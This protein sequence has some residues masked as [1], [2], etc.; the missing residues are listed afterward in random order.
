VPHAPACHLLFLPRASPQR[1]I[2]RLHTAHATPATLL[3]SAGRAGLLPM[4][5]GLL[6]I[7]LR[8]RCCCCL[9]RLHGRSTIRTPAA[10]LSTT[11]TAGSAYARCR[12]MLPHPRTTIL[13]FCTSDSATAAAVCSAY[14]AR[15][16]L[17]RHKRHT[18]FYACFYITMHCMLPATPAY[19]SASRAAL[20][21]LWVFTLP[22]LEPLHYHCRACRP[23][24][25]DGSVHLLSTYIAPFCCFLPLRLPT[26][27]AYRRNS[28]YRNALLVSRCTR[29]RSNHCA[30]VHCGRLPPFTAAAF[31][32]RF[33]CALRRAS[34]APY[35]PAPRLLACR[36]LRNRRRT[37]A[38]LSRTRLRRCWLFTVAF[39]AST[40][41]HVL[42]RDALALPRH[43]RCTKLFHSL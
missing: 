27:P 5:P 11:A 39:C 26:L 2:P 13:P 25:I 1:C 7:V 6:L 22:R 31:L 15:F 32:P 36:L 38:G 17:Y 33:C 35:A 18:R 40:Y 42:P 37:L 16:T 8:T 34:P 9:L 4:L 14:A 19:L 12:L 29:L 10:Y 30:C 3:G 24:F 41:S 20:S 21:F 43:C 23:P 28:T